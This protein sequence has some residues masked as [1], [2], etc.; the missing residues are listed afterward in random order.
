MKTAKGTSFR[1]FL[2]G[3]SQIVSLEMH[4]IASSRIENSCEQFPVGMDTIASSRIGNL[5]QAAFPHFLYNKE[6]YSFEKEH[7]EIL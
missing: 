1:S 5:S 2:M 3:C 4:T 6:R 7:K